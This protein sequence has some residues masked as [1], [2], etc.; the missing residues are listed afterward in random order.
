MR[1]EH[2][3]TNPRASIHFALA[4]VQPL[5]PPAWFAP[6][7]AALGVE[8]DADDLPRLARFLAFVLHANAQANLTSITDPDDAWRR[9]IL[10][11]LSLLAVLSDLPPGSRVADVGTGA[12]FPGMVLAIVLPHLRFTLMDATDKKV[13]F[14]RQAADALALANVTP[15][16]IRAEDA[17]QDRGEKT[18]SGRIGGHREQYDAVVARA[19][20]PLRVLAELT[21][22][23]AK[24]PA[25]GQPGGIVALIKGERAPQELDEAAGALRLLKASHAATLD[26]PTGRIVVLAKDA[27]TPR[28]YPRRDGE[29]KRAPLA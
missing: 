21:V 16:R 18:G 28:M 5:S 29:P 6:E 27:R 13:V 3:P 15:V 14:V 7:A 23:L 17:G 10:D 20:G 11:S 19:V 9:H 12:G 2:H 1:A 8:F 4:S 24:A 26:T 25:E 22:P